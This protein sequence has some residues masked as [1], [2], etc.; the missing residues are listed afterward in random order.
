M[1]DSH[2]PSSEKPINFR[3]K[4]ADDYFQRG[5]K[6]AQLGIPDKAV[7]DF[8]EAAWLEPENFEIQFKVL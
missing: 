3:P 6:S 7:E 5:L 4:T 8:E 2:K 1:T